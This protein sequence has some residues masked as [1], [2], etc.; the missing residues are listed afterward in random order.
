MIK[1]DVY[2][3]EGVYVAGPIGFME[4]SG[5]MVTFSASSKN[6][7]SFS[8]RGRG[9]AA[10]IKKIINQL[11][12]APWGEDNR[13]PQNIAD[14]MAYYGLGK[15]ALEW[16][17]K[18]LY[19]AG[20]LPGKVTG[21]EENAEIFEPLDRAQYAP[22]YSFL[23]NR[24]LF[25]FWIEYL[26]DWVWY[27]NC[28]PEVIFSNDCKTITHFVQQESCDCRFKQMNESGDID[29][30]FISKLWGMAGSQFAKF[31]PE[32]K[33]IGLYENPREITEADGV[34]VKQLDAIDMYDYI[35]SAKAIA[36]KLKDNDG[37]KSC[38]FPTNFPSP[39][40]TYYQVPSWD[41]ARLGGWVEIAC[42]IPQI[43]KLF[44]KKGQ[45]I[46]YHIEVPESYFEKKFTREKWATMQKDEKQVRK[47]RLDLLKEMDKYLTSDEAAF[48]TFVSFFDIDNIKKEE[49][50]RI[51]IT[52]IEGK[53]NIDKEILT[54]SAAD[55]QFLA[56]T[57]VHPTL[58]GAGTIG[59]G[60]QRTGGS[61]QR[62]AFLIYNSLLNLERQVAFE[63]LYL[64]RDFNGW[65]NDIVFRVLDT[66]LTT[67]DKNKGTEKVV[68]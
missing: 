14:Q 59:T 10:P 20:I 37:M 60:A 26:M 39:N 48:S 50:G 29:T 3:E 2:S 64:A 23:E 21:Y 45:R 28:F 9:T 62:E 58:F 43:L 17:A 40:K 16:K 34:Y 6:A 57:G 63:P 42:K 13:F 1:E 51:K 32:K 33:V 52:P 67:L 47:A 41:G 25:R 31:D 7:G 49:F 4:A 38:I 44:L 46:Q 15:A 24:T 35:N 19:G 61:D 27:G 5:S 22:V 56:A 55:L 65:E 12:V 8:L 36:A 68:S 30:V 18:A 54:T 11:N 66:K 53:Y